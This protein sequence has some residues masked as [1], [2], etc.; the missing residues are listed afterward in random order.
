VTV[1]ESEREVR[2]TRALAD[3]NFSVSIRIRHNS[4]PSPHR[5]MTDRGRASVTSCVS[6]MPRCGNYT[7]HRSLDWPANILVMQ[8]RNVHYGKKVL[9]LGLARG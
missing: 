4:F 6:I 2:V 9:G 5:I 7:S 8:R 1:G 3:K